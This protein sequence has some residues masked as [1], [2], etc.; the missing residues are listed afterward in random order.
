MASR[1]SRIANVLS[2]SSSQV[3]ARADA[4]QT[5]ADDQDVDML[6]YFVHSENLLRWQLTG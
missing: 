1:D 3:T 4:R 2:G 5:G 6:T